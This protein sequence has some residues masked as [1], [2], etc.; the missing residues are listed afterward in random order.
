MALKN[1][2]LFEN[3]FSN[4]IY[5]LFLASGALARIGFIIGIIY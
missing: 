5:A 3:L 4:L 2:D 1:R